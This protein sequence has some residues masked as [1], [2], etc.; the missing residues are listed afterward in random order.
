MN[1]L[2]EFKE[3][4]IRVKILISLYLL[5]A[6]FWLVLGFVYISRDSG[7]FIPSIIFCTT[8]IEILLAYGTLQ[9]K[10]F[11][12][13]IGIV[14]TVINIF[15]TLFDQMGIWDWGI[16]IVYVSTL[17]CLLLAKNSFNKNN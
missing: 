10:K 16:L 5:T 4:D 1:F 2:E 9:L 17:I 11:Y 8:V 3:R 14:F 12:F 6:L 13:W 15:L 7:W